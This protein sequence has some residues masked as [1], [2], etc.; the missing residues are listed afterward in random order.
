[1]A[2]S[3]RH[4]AASWLCAGLLF[5]PG[6][7]V[8]AADARPVRCAAGAKDMAAGT[9]VVEGVVYGLGD[10]VT[11]LSPATPA[12]WTISRCRAGQVVFVKA[13][14]AQQFVV[15]ATVSLA[16]VDPWRDERHFADEVRAMFQRANGAG[17]Q[18]LTT[19]AVVSRQVGGWPCV[20]I[21][22]SGTASDG[23]TTDLTVPDPWVTREFVRACHL[24]D[25]A[26]ARVAVLT[27][28]KLTGLRDPGTLAATAQA[29]LAGVTLPPAL[30]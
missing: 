3:R 1:M 11:V 5:A 10:G 19:D 23:K 29:F 13:D 12:G 2:L 28:L 25:P 15:T 6:L 27:V 20:D 24:T 8:A 22:R 4:R 16:T 21:R 18:H 17:D 7:A 9:P 30:H 14:D 26:R